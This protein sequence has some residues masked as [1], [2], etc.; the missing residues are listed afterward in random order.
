MLET[1]LDALRSGKDNKVVWFNLAVFQD[2]TVRASTWTESEVAL[3]HIIEIDQLNSASFWQPV[4]TEAE[5]RLLVEIRNKV[6]LALEYLPRII[7]LLKQDYIT[8]I[9][10]KSPN[11]P[12]ALKGKELITLYL[13]ED[14]G[15]FSQPSRIVRALEGF[16]ELYEAAA[17]IAALPHDD[18]VVLACDS[19]S[20]K[21]FDLLGAAKL[22]AETRG[23]LSDIWDRVVFHRQHQISAN[24]QIIA[25][26]LP[27]I[28]SI[29]ELEEKQSL[30]P[31]QAELIR[32]KVIN[33]AMNFLESGAYTRD[34]EMQGN[35]SP[36]Q[37]MRPEQKLLAAPSKD[38]G[39]ITAPPRVVDNAPDEAQLHMSPEEIT[40]LRALI[41]ASEQPAPNKPRTRGRKKPSI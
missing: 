29:S 25:E 27:L 16:S 34:M 7:D 39:Q 14:Q 19:G 4:V 33:G 36:R 26:S 35:Q 20:D 18:L 11:L 12:E 24:L 31:E 1:A 23:I 10:D 9:Q 5:P 17:Q 22:M 30:G 3:A 28:A 37:L 32:R 15:I 21:S 13:A 38:D 40:R 6:K 41:M 8:Q 2:F